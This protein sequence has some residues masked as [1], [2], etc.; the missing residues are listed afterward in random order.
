[1]LTDTLRALERDGLL[2]RE[3]FAT[4]PVTVQYSLTSLGDELCTV[5]GSLRSWAYES[6]DAIQ[7][8]RDHYDE[9]PRARGPVTPSSTPAQ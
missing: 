4:V 1:M 3:A 9:H 7:A 6:M 8:A 5:M 2:E